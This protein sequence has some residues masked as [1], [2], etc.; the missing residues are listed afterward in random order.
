MIENLDGTAKALIVAGAAL[1]VLGSWWRWGRPKA[2]KAWETVV[3]AFATLVGT[4]EVRSKVTGLVI[5]E[6]QPGVGVQIANLTAAHIEL[7]GVV[8]ELVQQQTAH[9][10]LEDRVDAIEERTTKAHNLLEGR[11][12]KLEQGAAERI[13]SAGERIQLFRVMEEAVKATPDVE[14]EAVDVETDDA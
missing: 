3:K 11:V 5:A 8:K 1:A 2:K 4:D 13:L 7:A 14:A 9:L 12:T 6:A 10:A